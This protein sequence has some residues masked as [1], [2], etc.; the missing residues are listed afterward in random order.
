MSVFSI[1]Q[2]KFTDV[3]SYRKYQA[4]APEVLGKLG[5]KVHVA[6]ENVKTLVGEWPFDKLVI[7]EF[8]DNEHMKTAMTDPEY[9][10]IGK[11]RDAGTEMVVLRA[12]GISA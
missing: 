1:V 5:V 9:V 4:K 10:E 12:E 3:E 7:L 2:I 8:K 6:D 11:D